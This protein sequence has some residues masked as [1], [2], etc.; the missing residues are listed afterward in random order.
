M[1]GEDRPEQI[2]LRD[3][4]PG[5]FPELLI[6]RIPL[7][8]PGGALLRHRNSPSG[9][10]AVKIVRSGGSFA[11]DVDEALDG[12]AASVAHPTQ[13][14]DVAPARADRWLSSSLPL[15]KLAPLLSLGVGASA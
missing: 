9:K 6:F 5:R 14:S 7:G 11:F 2:A 8:N 10:A 3:V 4:L 1:R 15:K 13:T 12:V